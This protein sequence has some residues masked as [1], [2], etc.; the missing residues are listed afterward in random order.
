MT[1]TKDLIMMS[2]KDF[3]GI[4]ILVFII[5]PLVLFFGITLSSTAI[6]SLI[7]GIVVFIWTAAALKYLFKK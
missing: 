4:V 6:Y 2:S 5:F 3:F 1:H 7:G